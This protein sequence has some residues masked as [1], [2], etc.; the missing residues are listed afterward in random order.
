MKTKLT[1]QALRLG[2]I[3]S[4]FILA[5]GGAWAWYHVIP[6]Q[7]PVSYAFQAR[8][9]VPGL[10]FKAEPVTGN[11]VEILATTNLINGTFA[12]S[13]GQRF[14]VFMGTWDGQDPKQMSVVGHTPDICWV[15]AG[16]TQMPM[17]HPDKLEL[18]FR[19]TRL[20]FEVRV[21]KAPQ[22]NH[23][24]LTVW[25]T[26]VSGQVYQEV[27]RFVLPEDAPEAWRARSAYGARHV[28]KGQLFKAISERIP[29]TGNKQFVRFS[30]PLTGDLPPALD[31]LK[32]FG[33]QWLELQVTRR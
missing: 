30:T 15:G 11:A 16:W 29:G 32:Q 24:E 25:A 7:F 1:S 12:R 19:G 20:P 9:H 22:G 18:D 26:L 8:E 10:S 31:S 2:L 14:M 13:G 28:L 33:E 17:N 4:F 27:G 5:T 3:F 6:K 23:L 21:F